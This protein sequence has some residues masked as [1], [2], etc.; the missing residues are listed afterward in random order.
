[1]QT[2]LRTFE[3]D[4]VSIAARVAG[5]GPLVVLI[6]GF[7]SFS[8]AWR[9]QVPALAEAGYRVAALDVRGYGGSSRPE[10][11]DA[12]RMRLLVDDVV[13]VIDGLGEPDATVIGH[14]WGAGIAWMTALLAPS[15]VR[16]VAGLSVPYQPPIAFPPSAMFRQL[17]GDGRRFYMEYFAAPGEAEQ[18]IEGDVRGWLAGM[19]A[20][21]W[22]PTY[23]ELQRAFVPD[24]RALRD[25]FT[26]SEPPEW[27][28]GEPFE[29]LVATFERTGFTGALNRYRAMELDHDDLAEFRSRPIEQPALFIGGDRDGAM[30]MT[31]QAIEA[32]PQTL[33]NL[34]RK[35][36]LQNCGHWIP[37]EKPAEVN[38]L[39]LEFLEQ[40]R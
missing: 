1:M 24:G 26:T 4:A 10:S 16:A 35:V 30:L 36:V 7:P 15:R 31:R 20:S 18:E 27:L 17:S 21:E 32:L 8:G 11:I 25:S 22:G 34:T 39:L 9:H 37:E 29:A 12:Y 6:H 13:A 40:T 38:R 2:T 28:A 33:P 23:A 19:Y 3:H 5:D 14:D